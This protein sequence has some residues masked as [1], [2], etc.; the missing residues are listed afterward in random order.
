[1]TFNDWPLPDSA[2]TPGLDIGILRAT[3]SFASRLGSERLARTQCGPLS[4]FNGA[5]VREIVINTETTGLR[6]SC[7]RV[8][9]GAVAL[10]AL[11]DEKLRS[12]P[13]FTKP[14]GEFVAFVDGAALVAHKAAFDLGFLNAELALC[15][16]DAFSRVVDSVLPCGRR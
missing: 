13:T 10:H 9:A 12:A 11:T 2:L 8:P 1:M 16:L 3:I 6:P 5:F 14:A 15:G 7:R 4:L